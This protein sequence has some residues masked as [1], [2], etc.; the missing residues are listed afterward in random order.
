MHAF[1]QNSQNWLAVKFDPRSVMMVFGEAE[2]MQ[3]VGD[4]INDSVWRDLGDQL[5]L[6]PLGK[7]VDRYQY[8]GETTWRR[9]KWSNHI[10]AP[11]GERLGW[12]YG[13]KIVSW[14]MR[15]IAKELTVL[16]SPHQVL[17][18]R[19]CGGPPKTSSVCLPI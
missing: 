7:L 13:D 3:D 15:L 18:I 12:R 9:C 14:D 11:A 17:Y 19:H 5:V 6:N 10:K 8:M 2:A 4:E 16:E 1:S